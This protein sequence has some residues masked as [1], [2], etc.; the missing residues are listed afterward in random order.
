MNL[1]AHHQT[2]GSKMFMCEDSVE[3]GNGEEK[4]IDID[5]YLAQSLSESAKSSF[6]VVGWI[7]PL[8]RASVLHIYTC[9]SQTLKPTILVRSSQTAPLMS[10]ESAPHSDRPFLPCLHRCR[11]YSVTYHNKPRYVTRYIIMKFLIECTQVHSF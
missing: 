8:C 7:T 3:V 5:I 1:G 10:T 9:L 11:Q 4:Y 6:N 2:I